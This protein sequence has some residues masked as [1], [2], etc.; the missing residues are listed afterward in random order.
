MISDEYRSQN[1]GW[2]VSTIEGLNQGRKWVK[3]RM[4]ES[5]FYPTF[6]HFL[7]FHILALY[8]I[9]LALNFNTLALNFKFGLTLDTW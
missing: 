6:Y 1:Q 9:S 7:N 8:F 3:I 4:V 2:Q 5:T